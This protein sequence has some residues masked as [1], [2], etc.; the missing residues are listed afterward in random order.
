MK[1]EIENSSDAF[2]SIC[3]HVTW[4]TRLVTQKAIHSRPK[5]LHLLLL[6]LEV[7][8]QSLDMCTKEERKRA[9]KYLLNGQ[10]RRLKSG[11]QRRL[12]RAHEKVVKLSRRTATASFK[13]KQLVPDALKMLLL[14]RQI[15]RR[16]LLFQS[17]ENGKSRLVSPPPTSSNEI[18]G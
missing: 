15:A 4:H 10:K 1:G 9:A 7:K 2:L 6:L 14:G 12:L 13:T 3:Q 16:F 5:R 8:H 17:F 18:Y 11:S